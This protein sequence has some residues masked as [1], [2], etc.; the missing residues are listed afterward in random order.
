MSSFSTNLAYIAE[1][2]AKLE[3]A[4]SVKNDMT[5]QQQNSDNI[6]DSFDVSE[7]H[8]QAS[9]NKA[10][11][12]EAS[13]NE[14]SFSKASSSKASESPAFYQYLDCSHINI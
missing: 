12:N 8:Q 10:S 5:D 9:F 4:K 14:A 6:T 13:F 3:N 1:I 2:S 7:I 11:L